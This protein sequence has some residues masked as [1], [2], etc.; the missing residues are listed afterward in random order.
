[1]GTM[2]IKHGI[3][4]HPIV[5]RNP[6]VRSLLGCSVATKTLIKP[7]PH[8]PARSNSFPASC[9]CPTAFASSAARTA[10]SPARSGAQRMA[11]KIKGSI[12]GTRLCTHMVAIFLHKQELKD[13]V[14]WHLTCDVEGFGK[15][16][17]IA[18]YSILILAHGLS[19]LVVSIHPPPER[20]GIMNHDPILKDDSTR[21]HV[22]R[23]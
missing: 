12:R 15:L 18:P 7:L 17:L 21:E 4:G 20:N 22:S 6:H 8:W 19:F 16:G 9:P 10:A 2:M 1:M 5:K 11:R 3:L 23:R 14:A 13:N